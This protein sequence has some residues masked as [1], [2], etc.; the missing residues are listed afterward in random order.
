MN[1]PVVPK[2]ANYSL[3]GLASAANQ[4]GAGGGDGRYLA[5]DH[6]TGAITIGTAKSPFDLTDR[7][8]IRVEELRYGYYI[9]SKKGSPDKANMIPMISGKPKPT[10]PNGVYAEYP[11]PGP[12]DIAELT[13]HPIKGGGGPIEFGPTGKSSQNRIRAVVEAVTVQEQTPGGQAGFIHPVVEVF[14]NSWSGDYGDTYHWDFKVTDWL[15]G[16]GELLQSKWEEQGNL[17]DASADE[18]FDPMG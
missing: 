15:D 2:K 12:Q 6:K 13:L 7:Y 16:S 18:P 9:F 17:E 3:G 10:P 11:A 8:A 1:V 14:V 5:I 4:V